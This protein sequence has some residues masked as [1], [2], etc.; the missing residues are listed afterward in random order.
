M[1][2]SLADDE[3]NFFID[4]RLCF[5]ASK[6]HYSIADRHHSANSGLGSRRIEPAEVF[7]K[8]LFYLLDPVKFDLSFRDFGISVVSFQHRNRGSL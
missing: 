1:S 5:F 8:L 3:H 4:Q 2:C 7:V 6:R